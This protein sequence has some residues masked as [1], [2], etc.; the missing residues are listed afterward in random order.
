MTI[1]SSLRFLYT[2]GGSG[3]LC[4]VAKHLEEGILPYVPQPT[5]SDYHHSSAEQPSL[6]L[7]LSFTMRPKSF[8]KG[9]NFIFEF[10]SI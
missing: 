6:P 7:S 3:L 2:F 10:L 8:Q 4:A 1:T 5:A 9:Q